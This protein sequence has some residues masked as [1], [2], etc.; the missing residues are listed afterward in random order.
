VLD[1]GAHHRVFDLAV[2]QIDADFVTGPEV[3]VWLF[4]AGHGKDSTAGCER[5]YAQNLQQDDELPG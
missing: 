2:I 5:I 1:N 4:L 3:P